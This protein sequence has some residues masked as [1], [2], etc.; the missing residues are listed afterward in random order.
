MPAR[1]RAL[2]INVTVNPAPA[3]RG[4]GGALDLWSLSLLGGLSFLRFRRKAAMATALVV[5]L[6]TGLAIP[7][8]ASAQQVEEIV[9]TSRR[10]EENLKEVPLSITAFDAGTIESAGITSSDG[11]RQPDSR[12]VVS[13]MPSARTCRCRSFAALCPRISSA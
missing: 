1:R 2:T 4:G 13:S 3:G 11:R 5:V 6:G 12:P 8:S 10:I 7:V 9:V